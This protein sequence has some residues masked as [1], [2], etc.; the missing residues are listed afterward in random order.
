MGKTR[1]TALAGLLLVLFSFAVSEKTYASPQIDAGAMY[2]S[3]WTWTSNSSMARHSGFE[4]SINMRWL[5][6]GKPVKNSSSGPG[7]SS[8]FFSA[9]ILLQF[10]DM[11]ASNWLADG[12]RYRA[13]NALGMGPEAGIGMVLP[14]ILQERRQT[15]FLAIS[16]IANF[17]KYTST[18]LY[19]AYWSGF[20]RLSWE[21]EFANHWAVGISLPVEIAGRSDG[22]SVIAGIR[23]GLSYAF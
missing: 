6:F 12:S 20:L 14:G 3:A 23:A 4:A 16:P 11:G 1:N 18:T 10:L 21:A 9:G 22:T 8:L 2:A 5:F 15:F 19:N 13:W 7:Q 17:S